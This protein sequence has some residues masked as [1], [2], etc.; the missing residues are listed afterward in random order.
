MFSSLEFRLKKARVRGA[1]T[2]ESV[3]HCGNRSHE[4]KLTIS[5][6]RSRCKKIL[7]NGKK[8]LKRRNL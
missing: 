2:S 8:N 3:L 1:R 7:S 5:Y 6:A 4:I